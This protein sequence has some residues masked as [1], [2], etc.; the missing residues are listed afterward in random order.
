M[1]ARN[2]SR[3]V[4]G[5]PFWQRLLI[6]LVA[7]VVTSL[8]VGLIWR[9]LFG[10][11]LPSYLGG[12]IGGLTAVPVWEFLKRIGPGARRQRRRTDETVR[13]AQLPEGGARRLLRAG[14]PIP[15]P[16]PDQRR[17]WA[18]AVGLAAGSVALPDI[19]RSGRC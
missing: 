15:R 3:E 4:P 5:M 16:E 18:G 13:S 1:V 14:L 19:R 17:H 2:R 7:M 8:V 9:T 11:E 12:V 6:T 10:F